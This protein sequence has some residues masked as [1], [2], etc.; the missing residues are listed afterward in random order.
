MALEKVAVVLQITMA[1][2]SFIFLEGFAVFLEIAMAG[3]WSLTKEQR[4]VHFDS[5]F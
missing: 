1:E 5:R 3:I 4:M 2:R